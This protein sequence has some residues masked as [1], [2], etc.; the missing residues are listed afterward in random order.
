MAGNTE[1]EREADHKRR[2]AEVQDMID[3]A[4][5]RVID[6]QLLQEA[7]D[8]D[9]LDIQIVEE[10]TWSP[11]DPVKNTGDLLCEMESNEQRVKEGELIYGKRTIVCFDGCIRELGFTAPE[12]IDW[13]ATE[14]YHKK[15]E[16]SDE[17]TS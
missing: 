9:G 17:Q 7:L 11:G 14:A 15:A 4:R 1:E 12:L 13:S 2:K 5:Q 8:R 16:E 6:R 10:H 3:V